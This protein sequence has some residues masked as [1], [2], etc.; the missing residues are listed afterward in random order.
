MEKKLL[1]PF[2]V[3]RYV[4]DYYFC[5]RAEETDFLRK[6]IRNG[7]DVAIFAPRRMGKSGLIRH[8]FDNEELQER[9]YLIFIDIYATTSLR[10][11]TALLGQEVYEQIV[12]KEKS[13]MTKMLDVVRSFRPMA[14]FDAVTGEPKIELSIAGISNPELTLKEIFRFLNEA[15]KPCIVAIDEFQQVAG[16][17]DSSAEAT[18]RTL[19]QG[20]PNA[21]FIFSGSEQTMMAE[22]FT[23][24][25]KPFFQS[26]I[27]VG[28]APIPRETYLD[29]ACRLFEDYGKTPDR[30]IFG[31]IY[32]MMEGCTWF[33]QMLMNEVFTIVSEG[34]PAASDLIDEALTNVIGTQECAYRELLAQHTPNQRMLLKALAKAPGG[35]EVTS[36]D[37]FT[38][39]GFRSASQVQSATLALLKSGE[40]E[41]HDGRYRIYDFFYRI[42]LSRQP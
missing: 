20:C 32:D 35:A 25:A 21:R 37:F 38:R 40:L 7:R 14:G 31:R 24:K 26:C 19:M 30:E 2:V 9:N 39:A 17:K 27:T 16:Y 8:F 18:L 5:D 6:Q 34:E 23:S 11:L 10:E 3:G 28:L 13:L 1:N 42:W 22:M 36:I 15:Q 33:V 4:S 41:R 29:F 12:S